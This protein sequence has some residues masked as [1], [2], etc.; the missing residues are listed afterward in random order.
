[1][2]AKL[3]G[4]ISWRNVGISLVAFLG[5]AAGH[6]SRRR[7]SFLAYAIPPIRHA[8]GGADYLGFFKA[9]GIGRQDSLARVE[10]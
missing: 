9:E 6:R 8:T 3:A 5:R 7:S 4:G 10:R 2:M 1:M